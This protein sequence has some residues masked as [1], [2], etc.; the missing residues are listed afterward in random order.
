MEI[1][2]FQTQTGRRSYNPT[3]AFELSNPLPG[4]QIV[5]KSQ[6]SKHPGQLYHPTQRKDCILLEYPWIKPQL[7]DQTTTGN[8]PSAHEVT[9][10]AQSK[11]GRNKRSQDSFFTQVNTQACH[12]KFF[13]QAQKHAAYTDPLVM[14]VPPRAREGKP[15]E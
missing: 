4:A 10:T 1:L 7:E 6:V 2:H 5:W 3:A 8:A 9:Q 14:V 13:K 12:I 15:L 11:K